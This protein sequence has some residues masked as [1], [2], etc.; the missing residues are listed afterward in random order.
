MFDLGQ[1]CLK[2]FYSTVFGFLSVFYVFPVYFTTVTQKT[3]LNAFYR[4]LIESALV[5]AVSGAGLTLPQLFPVC[6]RSAL[7]PSP[8]GCVIGSLFGSG[9]PDHAGRRGCYGFHAAV[10]F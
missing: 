4:V 3:F 5:L 2:Y 1:L 9:S 6:S 7:G 8:A 10:C